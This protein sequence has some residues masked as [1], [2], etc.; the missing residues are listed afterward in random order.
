[1]EHLVY[2]TK[3]KKGKTQYHL[4][5]YGYI[6]R[7]DKNKEFRF[8]FTGTELET[9]APITDFAKRNLLKC[10]VDD[11]GYAPYNLKESKLT[12]GKYKSYKIQLWEDK[13]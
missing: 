8:D 7:L 2:L 10:L 6:A 11:F 12:M 4:L 1:M 13:I 3:L 5:F 9:N